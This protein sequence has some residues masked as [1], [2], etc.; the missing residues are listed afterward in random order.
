MHDLKQRTQQ[1]ALDLVKFCAGL[2]KT[3]EFRILTSQLIRAATSAGAGDRALWRANPRR[4][5]VSKVGTVEAKADE[6]GYPLELIERLGIA[7][8]PSGVLSP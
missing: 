1:F 5:L 3:Q 6:C 7:N 8:E 4:D 2:P